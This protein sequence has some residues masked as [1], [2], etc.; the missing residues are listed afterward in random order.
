MGNY[1][2]GCMSLIYIANSFRIIKLN[3][4]A[5]FMREYEPY[6][7]HIS[8]S[9]T[10]KFDLIGLIF[11]QVDKFYYLRISA[12]M[13]EMDMPGITDR[14]NLMSFWNRIRP[15]HISEPFEKRQLVL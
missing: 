4:S 9:F 6:Y 3:V 2:F 5:I 10:S 12:F 14:I 7:A 1:F 8:C 11:L 13:E 15:V